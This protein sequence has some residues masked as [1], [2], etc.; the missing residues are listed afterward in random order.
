L[1]AL[2]LDGKPVLAPWLASR[3]AKT[4]QRGAVVMVP[5]AALAEGQHEL[6]LAP[7]PSDDD[8]AAKV[9]RIPFW[10]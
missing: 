4:G 5:I 9:Q 3:D 2:T 7:L 8:K 1:H 10:K 6:A